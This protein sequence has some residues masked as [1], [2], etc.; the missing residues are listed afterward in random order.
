MESNQAVQTPQ[1]EDNKDKG[2]SSHFT[3]YRRKA[4]PDRDYT[5]SF[6]LTSSRPT[7]FSSIFQ[8][9]TRIQGQNQEIFHPKAERVRPNDPEAVGVC[10][11][12]TKEPEIVLNTSRIS[13]PNNGSITPTRN[14]QS[15]FT[16]ESNL[17]GDA[18][19]LQ[20]SQFAEKTQKQFSEL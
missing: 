13:S 1:A 15:V 5:D 3:S 14:E 10:E 8:E 7:H 11:R 17:N 16:P 6:R 19:W 9:K 12:S 4:E 20:M 18:L 2:E